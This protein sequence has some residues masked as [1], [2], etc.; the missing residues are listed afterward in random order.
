MP[1]QDTSN[2]FP[3]VLEVFK[4]LPTLDVTQGIDDL[5]SS[6][7]CILRSR[8]RETITYN[9]SNNNVTVQFVYRDIVNKPAAEQ[10]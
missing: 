7:H 9:I 4:E 3:I 6:F 5:A 2:P 1:D 10:A 8:H